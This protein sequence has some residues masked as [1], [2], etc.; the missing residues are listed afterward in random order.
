M[1]GGRIVGTAG[2]LGQKR[3]VFGKG[4][5]A[6]IVTGM[7]EL[8]SRADRHGVFRDAPE[9]EK[10]LSNDG[11]RRGADVAA[12]LVPGENAGQDIAVCRESKFAVPAGIPVAIDDKHS[13]GRAET[14]GRD[15]ALGK[16][17]GGGH[18]L[19]GIGSPYGVESAVVESLALKIGTDVGKK[20]LVFSHEDDGRANRN[21]CFEKNVDTPVH[22]FEGARIA[23]DGGMGRGIETIDGKADGCA[24]LF[25]V[26]RN[27]R[28]DECPVGEYIYRAESQ[29]IRLAQDGTESRRQQRF[30]ADELDSI[31]SKLADLAEG[32]QPFG[33]REFGRIGIGV[34]ES[35]I[36]VY[37]PT[38]AMCGQLKPNVAQLRRRRG[39]GNGKA[40]GWSR[41]APEDAQGDKTLA[42]G[43][44]LHGKISRHTVRKSLGLRGIEMKHPSRTERMQGGA[45]RSMDQRETFP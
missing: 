19:R 27:G 15:K 14:T 33:F 45:A 43:T 29:G 40:V 13:L 36:A 39:V 37:A 4:Q 6:A 23:C 26:G 35:S 31:A 24:M 34:P 41:T 7:T 17:G 1:P 12:N 42:T 3:A 10:A 5:R 44:G 38:V 18:P 9:L 32:I 28:S 20:V 16:E 2:I 21:V 22:E 30:S 8:A 25:E 11:V